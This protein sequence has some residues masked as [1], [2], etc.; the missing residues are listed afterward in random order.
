MKAVT[1]IR[2]GCDADARTIW[3]PL[4]P[5]LYS[6]RLSLS[7]PKTTASQRVVSKY[8]QHIRNYDPRPKM[9]GSESDSFP[10]CPYFLLRKPLRADEHLYNLLGLAVV[11]TRNPL[12]D[13]AP[14]LPNQGGPDIRDLN[15]HLYPKPIVGHDVKSLQEKASDA[16]ARAVITEAIDAFVRRKRTG[17]QSYQ[18]PGFRRFSM[19][20]PKTQFERLMA[21]KSYSDAIFRKLEEQTNAKHK[22][23]AFITDILT[24]ADMAVETSRD[25]QTGAGAGFDA[26]VGAAVGGLGTH[27]LDVS[28]RAEVERTRHDESGGVYEGEVVVACGYHQIELVEPKGG[29]WQRIK[30]IF[31]KPKVGNVELSTHPINPRTGIYF[32]GNPKRGDLAGFLGSTP[33]GSWHADGKSIEEH[34]PDFA[35]TLYT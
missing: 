4:F 21:N 10:E 31:V 23:L 33:D 3:L 28:G 34:D 8:E 17:S 29:V 13:I 12:S 35:F 18:A 2:R 24:C 19:V 11:N 7:S 5:L 30:G 20:T 14:P 32:G 26:P 1:R 25:R 9:S 27:A 16:N 15:P 6:N 22:T